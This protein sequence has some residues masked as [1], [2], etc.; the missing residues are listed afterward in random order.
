MSGRRAMCA[1]M[2]GLLAGACGGATVDRASEP[3]GGGGSTGGAEL[4]SGGV[5]GGAANGEGGAPV[6]AASGAPSSAGGAMSD[7]EVHLYL[8]CPHSPPVDGTPCP[9]LSQC[10][11]P[12]GECLWT[13][14]NCAPEGGVWSVKSGVLGP[15]TGT[16]GCPI[17]MPATGD[18]CS[19]QGMSCA[20]RGC[21]EGGV[22]HAL[23]A[24]GFWAAET[25]TCGS[26]GSLPVEGGVPVEAGAI[27][28]GSSA[29]DGD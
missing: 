10:S 19:S 17:T 7:T 27:D 4:G 26:T 12:I 9:G 25:S 3:S 22:L 16:Y 14:A 24:V 20:Y 21:G 5:S 29:R 11:Y 2:L 28:A 13:N 8:S 1:V 15:C 18:R 23:C 6:F